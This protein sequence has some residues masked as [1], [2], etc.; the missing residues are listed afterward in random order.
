MTKSIDYF[1]STM[2]PWTFLGSGRIARLAADAGASLNIM[3]IN[4]GEVFAA[5]GGLPLPKRHP[6]RQA[7]RLAELAR[8]RHRLAPDM[9]I[10]PTHFPA[11]DE[12]ASRMVIAAK[13]AGE[14][15]VGL[16]HHLMAALWER[17]LETANPAV[18]TMLAGELGLDG[19]ALQAA[20]DGDAVS[21]ERTA[22]TA[23]AIERGVFGVPWYV[24]DGENFWGQDRLDFV[25]ERLKG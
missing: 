2:S 11:N 24:I 23:L 15:A 14:D 6:A 16:A 21:A 12:P 20:G 10:E 18:L 3:P 1:I 8:W 25:A 17:N 22:N 9:V 5:T 19:G 4:T 13:Q 7:Y